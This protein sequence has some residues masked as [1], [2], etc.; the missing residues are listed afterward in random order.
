MTRGE[1][2]FTVLEIVAAATIFSVVSVAALGL[3][4]TGQKV[5]VTT[6]NKTRSSSRT[7]AVLERIL[8]ELRHASFN[9]EDVDEDNDAG[10]IAEDVNGNGVIEDDWSLADNETAQ[11]IS[12]NTALGGG[13]YSKKITFRFDGTRVWRESGDDTAV[14]ARDVRALTFTRRGSQITIDIT[15]LAGDGGRGGRAVS[16]SRTILIR[17]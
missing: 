17:N 14:L 7:L 6:G 11:S 5:Y 9:A 15:T 2:G 1:R 4:A 3:A 10:D 12:F 13:L 8:I 16:L